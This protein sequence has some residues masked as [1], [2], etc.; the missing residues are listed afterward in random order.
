MSAPPPQTC[1]LVGIPGTWIDDDELGI[2]VLVPMDRLQAKAEA[3]L[4]RVHS[5]SRLRRM[6]R[7]TVDLSFEDNAAAGMLSRDLRVTAAIVELLDEDELD[8][9]V[10][11]EVAHLERHHLPL[12]LPPVWA[13]GNR[14]VRTAVAVAAAG[15]LLLSQLRELDADRRAVQ[16]TGDAPALIRALRKISMFEQERPGLVDRLASSHPA[17]DV[18]VAALSL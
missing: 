11:H 6:P 10:A 7:L 9:V 1:L 8:G 14:V 3:S 4:R 17:T 12:V 15:P 13:I 16:I 2:N 18:R 5:R